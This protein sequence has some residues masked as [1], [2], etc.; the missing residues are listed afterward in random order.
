MNVLSNNTARRVIALALLSFLSGCGG[1]SGGDPAIA[2]LAPPPPVAQKGIEG[3]GIV[4]RFG[5][6]FSSVTVGDTTYDTTSA[7]LVVTVDDQVATLMDINLGN[8]VRVTATTVDDG[9]TATAMQ[10][11]QIND[12]EGPITAG[13]IDVDA[14]TFEVLGQIVR[15]VATTLFDSDISPPSLAGLADGDAVE[16]SVQPDGN[17]AYTASR[18]ERDDDAGDFEITGVVSALDSVALRF[19]IG[20][21][22]VDYSSATLEDFGSG[23]IADGDT[24][25][26]EGN[27][28]DANGVLLATKVENETPGFTGADGDF[29]S[30]EG[31]VTRFVSITD[32]DVDGFPVTTTA[33]TVFDDGVASDLALGVRVEIDGSLDANGVLVATK[34]D[35]EDAEDN[36]QIEVEAPVEAVDA[37]ASTVTV[38]GLTVF[39]DGST[40]IKDDTDANLTPFTLADLMVGDYVEIKAY[41]DTA[42][43]NRL[44]AVLLERDDDDDGEVS[45]EGPASAIAQPNLSIAGVAIATVGNTEFEDIN[46][47]PISADA[48]FGSISD[49]DLVEADGAWDGTTLTADSV[50]RED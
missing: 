43:A 27:A 30:F 40:L 11:N 16:V 36:A 38:L 46:D 2:P 37:A 9:V 1:G 35:F 45:I 3:G 44:T 15:V 19:N 18:I 14:G 5:A 39:V 23:M 33:Q 6:N 28:L 13:S 34:V 31:F 17:G 26:V 50:E 8:I 42:S 7:S 29:G 10:I 25:E 24:V 21:L 4:S 41:F 20:A 48:F 49:G 47:L 32:F 22:V 12:L